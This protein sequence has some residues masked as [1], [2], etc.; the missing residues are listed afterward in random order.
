[1][2]RESLFNALIGA[3][4]KLEQIKADLSAQKKLIRFLK[5]KTNKTHIP[6]EETI[7]AIQECEKGG[8]SRTY[9]NYGEFL[10]DIENGLC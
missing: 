3:E 4:K 2:P 10:K 6:N 1:M 9:N 8:N 7:K 5:M